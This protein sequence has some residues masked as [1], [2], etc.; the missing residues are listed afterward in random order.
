MIFGIFYILPLT[1]HLLLLRTTEMLDANVNVNVACALSKDEVPTSS[2]NVSKSVLV[3]DHI[4][5][6]ESTFETVPLHFT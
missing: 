1:S 6:F 4:I 5:G 3:L 2:G